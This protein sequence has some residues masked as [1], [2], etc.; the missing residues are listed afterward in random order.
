MTVAFAASDRL[1]L[2][3]LVFLRALDVFRL[4]SP[5]PAA[6]LPAAGT[7]PSSAPSLVSAPPLALPFCQFCFAVGPHVSSP[8]SP[9]LLALICRDDHSIREPLVRH[10]L[11]LTYF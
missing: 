2:V 11:F 1:A 9:Q 10:F 5:S 8:D 3:V 7:A 4:E 6:A